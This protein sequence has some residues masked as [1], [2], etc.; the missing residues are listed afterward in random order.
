AQ[1]VPPP[2][3]GEI[4][5]QV[6]AIYEHELKDPAKA[7]EAYLDVETVLANHGDTMEALTRV[8]AKTEQWHKS[9]DVIERRAQLAEVKAQRIEL[10]HRAGEIYAEK[11]GDA[12]EAE[13]RFV[14]AL[15]IDPTHVPSMT[16]LVEIYRKN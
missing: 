15:E 13:T 11:I 10:Y 6:G 12:K 9:A 7:I 1:L 4:H 3:A 8:Y 16:A 2:N 5:F 14:R